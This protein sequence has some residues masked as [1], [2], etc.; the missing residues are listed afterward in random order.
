MTFDIPDGDN[1]CYNNIMFQTI[2]ELDRALF[3]SINHLPH[4]FFFDSFFTFFSGVGYWGIIWFFLIFI[5]FI[6]EEVKDRKGFYA[7]LL[8]LL[9]STVIVEWI[10]KNIFMRGRPQLMIPMTIVVLD[11]TYSSSF[12]SGH[13]AM[14]FAGAYILAKEHEKWTP[15]YYLLA[16]LIAFS[17]IYLGKHYPSDVLVGGIL[18]VMI[19]YVCLKVASFKF[20]S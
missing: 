4:N 7:L 20:K 12:P 16:F 10:L 6:W 15:L 2:L 1:C 13:A 3:L 8:A 17:R 5:L 11:A 14:A 18:G 9:S 19:G